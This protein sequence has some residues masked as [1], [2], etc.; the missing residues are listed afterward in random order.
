MRKPR[1]IDSELKA[2]AERASDKAPIDTVAKRKTRMRFIMNFPT[3]TGY[4]C[5]IMDRLSS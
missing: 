5:M 4:Y 1:D 2:L 3:W